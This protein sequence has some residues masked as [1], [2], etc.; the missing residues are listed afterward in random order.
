M[1]GFAVSIQIFDSNGVLVQ[2]YQGPG[3]DHAISSFALSPAA[4]NPKSGS[5]NLASGD[6][7]ASYNGKDAQGAYLENGSYVLMVLSSQGSNQAKAQGEFSVLQSPDSPIVASVAPNPVL[8]GENFLLISWTSPN[9][10][11]IRI[12]NLRGELVKHLEGL[13]GSSYAWPLQDSRGQGV[14]G[15]IYLIF[16]RDETLRVGKVYKAAILR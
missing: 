8:R 1:G 5:L 10:V 13:T 3:S 15:G 6:W 11:A 16:V 12:F 9:P 2:E 14:S 4:F 7:S